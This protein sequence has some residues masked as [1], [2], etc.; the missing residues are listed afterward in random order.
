MRPIEGAVNMGCEWTASVW[1]LCRRLVYSEVVEARSN[2]DKYLEI[3]N[4]LI[5]MGVT[6]LKKTGMV[7][8]LNF[9]GERGEGIG[10]FDFTCVNLLDPIQIGGE[11]RGKKLFQ[12][13]FYKRRSWPP[14]L[15]DF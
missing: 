15:S 6:G 1:S 12:C 3:P 13:N 14:K 8:L 5:P 11:G 4:I 7:C 2:Y 9:F 10:W